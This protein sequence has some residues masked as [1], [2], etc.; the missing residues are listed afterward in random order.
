M[1]EDAIT[2]GIVY[3]RIP[4]TWVVTAED[5]SRRPSSQAFNNDGEG[6]PMSGYHDELLADEALGPSDV[7]AGHDGFFVSSLDVSF[8]LDEEQRVVRA[9]VDRPVHPCDVAHVHV[10]G[11]K[12]ASRR[13]RLSKHARWV[14]GLGPS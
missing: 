5:G 7:L 2:R 4:P 1:G 13:K 3:R 6:S 12:N 11:R 14:P 8:L 9:L 10:D